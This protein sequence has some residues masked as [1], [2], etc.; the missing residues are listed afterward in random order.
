MN[1]RPFSKHELEQLRHL[2]PHTKTGKI[3]ELLGRSLSSIFGMAYKLGLSKSDQYLNSPDACR[4]RRGER[5]GEHFR[6]A[7]GHIPANKGLRRPGY[8]PGRMA[9]TQFKK[10]GSTNWMPIGSTRLIDGYLY[11][12]VSDVRNVVHTV[13]WK[14][15]HRLIYE[16]AHG[17]KIDPKTH[18]LIFKDGDRTH[19]ELDNLELIT[20]KELRHRNSIHNL[21][22]EIK[23]VLRLKGAIKRVI[24]RRRKRETHGQEQAQR[25]A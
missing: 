12:K 19:I 1:G 6:Y 8:A 10:G 16:A 4:L 5:I 15:E 2:Y 9:D 18:A 23:E 25:S 14:L 22:P 7:K 17:V 11:R 20:R 3:A 13:N 21:P 24:T